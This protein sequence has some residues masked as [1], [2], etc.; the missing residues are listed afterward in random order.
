MIRTIYF[1]DVDGWFT[2]EVRLFGL[3]VYRRLICQNLAT[4]GTCAAG[5]NLISVLGSR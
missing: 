5:E 3:L 1:V 4:F 2:K